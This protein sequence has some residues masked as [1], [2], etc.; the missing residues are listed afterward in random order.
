MTNR[1]GCLTFFFVL[2][3]ACDDAAETSDQEAPR[4]DLGADASALDAGAPVGPGLRSTALVADRPEAY[5][6]EQ[7]DLYFDTLDSR[8]DPALVPAYSERVARWEWPPW[9]Y[10]TGYGREQI[11]TTTRGAHAIDPSTVES[12]ACRFFADQPFVRCYVV[13]RYEGGDCPIYE[14]FTYSDTG[15]MTF[16]EAWSDQPGWLPFDDP[17]DRWAEG[18]HIRRLS[19]RIPGLGDPGGLID[20]EAEWMLAAAEADPEVADF[21]RR[22]SNFWAA[23][24]E[25]LRASGPDLYARGCGW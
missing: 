6:L 11:I 12:R 24:G 18:A 9:L 15:E 10:L 4:Q 2:A 14:E 20:L 22:A 13:F 16:V 5:Y 7:A 17:M 25:A 23:F 3:T 1:L 8:A 19:T 21:V